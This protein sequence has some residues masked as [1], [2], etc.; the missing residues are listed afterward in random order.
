MEMDNIV[1]LKMSKNFVNE[2]LECL[3][4]NIE[5]WQRTKEYFESGYVDPDTPYVRE[6]DSLYE[7][8]ERENYYRGIKSDIEKQLAE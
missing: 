5:D 3:E 4:V 1:T 6:C 7:A 2:L 8:E